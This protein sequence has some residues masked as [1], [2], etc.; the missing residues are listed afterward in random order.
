MIRT[1]GSSEIP[2]HSTIPYLV[3]EW[4]A[5]FTSKHQ[6]DLIAKVRDKDKLLYIIVNHDAL[7]TDRFRKIINYI[8]KHRSYGLI[9]DESTAIKNH[10]AVRTIAALRL[11]DSAKFRRI[12]SGTPIVQ[13]PLD[14]YSQVEF[15]NKQILGFRSYYSFKTRYAEIRRISFG[16]RAFDK[17]VGFRDLDDLKHKLDKFSSFK[18]LDECVD[19]PDQV[20]KQI[21]IELT[22]TQIHAYRE[23]VEKAVLYIEEHEITAVNALSLIVRL[24]Q[25]VIGQLKAPDGTYISIQN[26]RLTA[27]K[28]V[29]EETP[30]KMLIWSTYVNTTKD[31]EKTLLTDAIV[32]YSEYSQNKRQ[33]LIDKWRVGPAKCLVLNPA[34]AGHGLTLNEAKT[35]VFYSNSYNLEYR[36]QALRRNYRIG[37]TEPTLVID[38]ITPG[39]VEEKILKAL[40]DKEELA[41]RLT[42]KSAILDFIKDANL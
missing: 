11:A 15:L 12:L 16:N 36:L 25:I 33:E 30:H 10:K 22:P 9:Y 39:T 28:E 8:V 4:G 21:L 23:L 32:I 6:N 17:I 41:K 14:I 38:F 34:S 35:A 31:I 29:V 40:T 26:N 24:H 13:S 3:F 20:S 27:L 7:T 1:W 5:T 2:K 42:T 19:L 37:Q 18:R